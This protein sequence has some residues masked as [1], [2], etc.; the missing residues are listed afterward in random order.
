MESGSADSSA[1]SLS[2]PSGSMDLCT[3][4][5]TKCSPTTSSST[6]GKLS[7]SQTLSSRRG[8]EVLRWSLFPCD[9]CE[10]RRLKEQ[11]STEDLHSSEALGNALFCQ[12]IWLRTSRSVTASM[13]DLSDSCC[14]FVIF[15]CRYSTPE[16][17]VK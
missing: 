5:P 17:H 7:I 10:Q 1:Y 11:D 6:R 15:C 16:Y 9:E 4:I 8:P 3:L 13:C 14:G 12:H 2:I